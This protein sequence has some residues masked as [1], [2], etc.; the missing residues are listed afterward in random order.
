MISTV[1]TLS[2]LKTPI[3]SA[4][5]GGLSFKQFKRTYPG[6][7]SLNFPL[8]LSASNDFKTKQ[9]SNFYLT[10]NYRF[11]DIF[12]TDSSILQATAVFGPITYG[13]EYLSYVRVDPTPYILAGYRP[14]YLNYFHGVFI[15]NG[16][17]TDF[18]V[19]IHDDNKCNI[20][21]TIE[22]KNYYLC[23]DTNDNLI[24]IKEKL[25]TFNPDAINPQDFNYMFSENGNYV[26]FFKTTATTTFFI[27]KVE[28][29]LK[30]VPIISENI[31]S[32]TSPFQLAANIYTYPT[33]P[34]DT[35]FIT[36]ANDNT[37]NPEKSVFNLKNNY[38][39]HNKYSY[40][41]NTKT[42]I[43]VLKNQLLQEDVFS[44]ANN[45]LSSVDDTQ[46]VS[47]TRIYSS[48]MED[49]KEEKTDVLELNY[50]IYNKTYKISPGSTVFTSPSSLFPF[51]KLNINDS[52][53][54]SSGAFSYISPLYADKI[55]H[56]SEE[57]QNYDGGQYLL[58][59]WLSGSPVS[60]KK[61]WVDRYY[62]PDLIDKQTA[63]SI[64]PI[65]DHTYDDAIEHMIR[66]NSD[67][68]DSIES[69]LFFDKKSDLAFVPSQTYRYDRM[70]SLP[71]LSSTFTYCNSY[72]DIYPVNYFKQIN[73]KGEMTLGF[74]FTGDMTPWVIKSDRNDIDSGLTITKTDS[75]VTISY[76]I[77]DPT[78]DFYDDTDYAWV[79][80]STTVNF[81]SLKDNFICVSVNSKTGIGYFYL[82]NEVVLNFTIPIYQFFIKQLIY[83]DFFM[84]FENSK[85]DIL[86]P[87]CPYIS[88]VFINDYFI[89]S[90]LVF[91]ISRIRDKSINDI[92]ITLPC[93]MR[94]STDT[95]DY[96]HAVCGSSSFKS[97]SIN[98]KVKNLDIGN[99]EVL[100]GL[101]NALMTNIE[102]VLPANIRINKID[103]ETY[104]R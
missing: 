27:T 24:F 96:I 9:Y 101:S 45:L 10:N 64:S 60:D 42:D 56:L 38:L 84:L 91:S 92:Y 14:D 3:L 44:S 66:T 17:G 35:S 2:S 36:Y 65:F 67:L 12:D 31:T 32:Y 89:E 20:F 50:V 78:R 6:N 77:Y 1:S 69:L 104:K 5:T 103:F 97:N 37:I 28:D 72:S 86:D 51:T 19:L 58:C 54:I 34:L 100:T 88:N 29:N 22:Y 33:D 8:C 43:V 61:T 73:T 26:S 102:Q 70:N 94:N 80:Y 46:F 62:Y 16:P 7:Y 83:G 11:S 81:K 40:P 55:Y 76:K 90:L 79:K 39:L 63:L 21:F 87:S 99:E 52:K 4:S 68:S 30:A 82:N 57:T 18:T 98:I 75:N 25:L 49:M 59:T 23:M 93:G 71:P 47:N 15:P 48:I 53:F 74:N 95:I 85:I 13:G 41:D